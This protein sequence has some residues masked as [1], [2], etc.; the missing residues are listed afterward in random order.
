MISVK[1]INKYFFKNKKNEIHVIDNTSLEL[2]DTGLVAL[3]GPSGSGKTTLLNTIGGLDKVNSGSIYINNE[4]ITRYNTSKIDKIR[5][6]N[7]G[8]IFQDYRLID[9]KSVFDNVA[10]VLYMLGI[11]D[12]EE[13]KKRVNYVL[14]ILGIYKYR[15]R[16][17][18]MLS[19]GERQRVGIARAIVKNPNVI[20]ADEPTGNLDSKNTIEIMN[21]IKSISKDKLVILVTHEKDLA[22][23]YASRV[24]ELQDGK[25]IS[26][27][28]NNHNNELDYRIDNK[29]YL[30]DIENHKNIKSDNLNIDLYSDD[31]T[32]LNLKIVVKNGNIYIESNKKDKI[33]VINESSSLELVNDNYKKISKES[34]EKYS[35]NYKEVLNN[36]YKPK[37][38]SIFNIF[39]LLTNGFKKIGNYSIIKKILLLGFFI[40]SMFVLYSVSNI[41]GILNVKDE[42]FV[43]HNKNYLSVVMNKIDVSDY[44]K[45]EKEPNIYYLLPGD[46]TVNF[47]IS[48]NYYYQTNNATDILSGSLST[49]DMITKKDIIYGNMPTND[50][51]IVVD[52]LSI[53]NMFNNYTAK[54]VGL[55]NVSDVIGL[56]AKIN[57]MKEFKIVGITDLGSPSIY[58]NKLLFINII[59]NSNAENNMDYR[60]MESISTEVNN[61]NL[62]DYNLVKED[63]ILKSGNYPENDYEVMVNYDYKDEYNLNKEIDVKVNDKKLKVVGYYT[64]YEYTSML[65][66]NN[67]IKYKL[68]DASNNITIYGDKD[69]VIEYFK[70]ENKNIIDVY[71]KDKNEYLETQKDSMTS[72]IIIA[73]VVLLISLVEIFLMI[74]SSFLSRIKEVGIYRAIGVKKKDIYKMFLGEILAIT[75]T[76]SLLGFIFMTYIL[77]GIIALPIFKDKF[78]LSPLVITVSLIIIFGFNILVGLIPV[79]N[80][81]RK[82]PSQILARIDVD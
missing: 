12:K 4:K 70:S 16:P 61:N 62:I 15:N 44:L 73:S 27:K 65:V 67:T 34:Y 66:N 3:L 23:F 82:T 54:Q 63:I 2:N 72:A 30:K 35:F 41:M 51:E 19:G 80:T 76:A 6:L 25:I 68:L 52:R 53:T 28:K 20:I 75:L 26:D 43:T 40:S 58:T 32:N 22:Y 69:K 81:L 33:E 50:Y 11:K 13:V 79:F 24:I 46:S 55:I 78:L 56:T 64:S 31:K 77:N 1:N 9:E 57:N 8:Y 21:I 38:T 7:I 74:R 39:T 60:Y 45:Y 47:N 17:T 14:N 49:I 59:S 29:I 37:Y 10:L 71:T 42:K 36:N 48:Y 5:N 18:N